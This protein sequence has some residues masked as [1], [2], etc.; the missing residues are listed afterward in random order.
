MSLTSLKPDLS[1]TTITVSPGIITSLPRGMMIFPPRF[2]H[3]I[4]RLSLSF[5]ESIEIP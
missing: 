3:A 1:V 5:N 2:M 4:R